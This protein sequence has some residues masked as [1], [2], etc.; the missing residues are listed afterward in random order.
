[1]SGGVE[2]LEVQIFTQLSPPWYFWA[3]LC[4]YILSRSTQALVRLL[5]MVSQS[6]PELSWKN[7]SPRN[8]PCPAS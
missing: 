2:S 7:E 5:A 6:E 4:S 3:L 8:L 1:M